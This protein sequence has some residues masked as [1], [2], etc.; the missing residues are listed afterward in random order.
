MAQRNY[1]YL[2]EPPSWAGKVRQATFDNAVMSNSFENIEVPMERLKAGD[3]DALAELFDLFRARLHRIVG[4]RLDRRLLGRV[5]T[6]DVL[7]ETYLAAADRIHHYLEDTSRSFFIWLRLVLNQTLVDIHRRHL[8]AQMRD[9]KRDIS[10]QG[11]RKATSTSMAAQLMGSATSPSQV[12]MRGEVSQQIEQAIMKMDPIDQEV[13]ALRH[14]EELSN[15]EV[16]EALKIK[17][18]AASIRY[19]RA[20]KRLGTVL[21]RTPGFQ[22]ESQD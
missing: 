18:K 9:A 1:S 2:V 19:V 16:A 13:L 10:L 17:Q 3:K 20:L 21:K 5:D 8:G 11:A 22:G 6:D 7:Q 4:F 15:S 14:F 12:A